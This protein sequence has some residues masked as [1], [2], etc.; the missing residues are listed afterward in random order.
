MCSICV[1]EYTEVVRQKITCPG[2]Q[3]EACKECIKKYILGQSK[4]PHCMSC[5]LGWSRE[6][7][8]E[9]VGK[10]FVNSTLKTHKTELLFEI[11]KSK[12]S[13]TMPRVENYCKMESLEQNVF[14]IDAEIKNIKKHL[15]DLKCKK[16][17]TNREIYILKTGKNS[18][19]S[20]KEF[21]QYCPV[22]GCNGF[23][24]KQYKCAVCA[25]WACKHCHKVLGVHQDDPHACDQAD[26][27]SVK[28]IKAQTKKCPTCYIPIQKSVGCNQ[29]WCTQCQFAFD[30]K[31]GE[32]QTGV[33]HNPH[34]FEAKRS[35]MVRAPGDNVCGGLPRWHDWA[36][37]IRMIGEALYR[38]E[39]GAHTFNIR[40]MRTKIESK[41]PISYRVA[42]ENVDT[43]AQLRRQLQTN[44][45]KMEELRINYILNRLSEKKYKTS[46]SKIETSREKKTAILNVLEIFNTVTIENFQSVYEILNEIRL[47][48]SQIS[49]KTDM[50]FITNTYDT[51]CNNITKIKE[52]SIKEAKKISYHYNQ[53]Y[54]SIN[55]WGKFT[56]E[57]KISRAEFYMLVNGQ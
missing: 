17:Q 24:S 22:D 48:R 11:E 18:K 41:A 28:L 38:L 53:S 43:I 57:T 50:E 10:S 9:N 29:M 45:G 52:Y 6:F 30:W 1:D 51:F 46:L 21:K 12:M 32:I 2:C 7:I 3:F 47:K 56:N 44:T 27:E 19:S 54:I 25:I 8:F 37:I 40:Q 13:S 5:K 42:A 33:I 49:T 31:T 15:H 36:D 23:L 4:D 14:V 26:V 16:E 39:Q 20:P 35:G 34:F 55:K